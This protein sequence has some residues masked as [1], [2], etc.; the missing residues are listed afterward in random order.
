MK[1]QTILCVHDGHNASAALMHNGVILGA[2]QEERFNRIKNYVGYPLRAVGFCLQLAHKKSLGIDIA[3]HTTI[4]NCPYLVKSK[5]PTKFKIRDY[6]GFWT[7]NY[8][9]KCFHEER[10]DADAIKY[11][12]W[13]RD[14][15][16]FSGDPEHYEFSFLYGDAFGN[17]TSEQ[18]MFLIERKRVL[19]QQVG[20]S[21]DSIMV[22]DHHACHESYA[23]YGSPFRDKPTAVLTLD[24]GGDGVNQTVS[25]ST[26]NGLVR[27]A[28]SSTNSL[29]KLWK[30]VCVLLAMKPFD[31]E[32]KVMG[33][34]PYA[35]ESSVDAAMQHLDGICTV[36]GLRIVGSKN[37]ADQ[38]ELFSYLRDK[39]VDHRFDSICGA[40][41]KYTEQVVCQL[42]RNVVR[43]TGV[44]NIVI[45]GGTSMNVK[46]NKAIA[47]LD[48][49]G[50]IFVCG[51]GG[52]ESLSIGGCYLL[53]KG[54]P[55]KPLMSLYLGTDVN[56]ELDS[57]D[58]GVLANEFEVR[59][60]VTFEE[61]A[62][63][64]R[65]GEIIGV[66]RGCAEFGARALGNRS[67]LADPSHGDS[68]KKI[69]EAIKNRDFWMP[70]ALS[71]LE[72][73]SDEILVNPKGLL[74]LHMSLLFEAKQQGYEK[75]KAGSHPYDMTI[76][77]QFVSKNYAPQYYQ[78]ISEFYA[79]TGIPALLNTSFNLHRE[80][81]VNGI[82][83][84]VRTFRNSGLDGLWVADKVYLSKI[85]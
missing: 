67:I 30:V 68:V 44:S 10:R 8:G 33:L 11:L 62:A 69:N 53:N 65:Q 60:D 80:P 51:S 83:D 13:L 17:R 54:H 21:V 20:V 34:A 49:V 42:V 15:E 32:Y 36:D 82:E 29:G 26:E 24:A 58:F 61:I 37:R 46:M 7:N 19:S 77:P 43:E 55:A 52:D 45:S 73:H 63:R 31:D 59:Y 23:Y 85:Q 78:L 3:A 35:K 22:L 5:W 50:N 4:Q 76:R 38:A 71:I 16:Q 64:L 27:L 79:Q 28:E 14:A 6:I 75:I 74:S 9:R 66:V 81:I 70:F 2:A 56:N 72:E 39:W 40:M 47:D 57:F 84:A 1:N 18:E 41:Q 25:I 12:T 48:V